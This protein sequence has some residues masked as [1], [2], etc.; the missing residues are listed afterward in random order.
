M[1]IQRIPRYLLLLKELIKHT[2]ESHPDFTNLNEAHDKIQKV[3]NALNEAER[4]AE[5]MHKIYLI[6]TSLEGDYD[7]R[8]TVFSLPLPSCLSLTN[9]SRGGLHWNRRT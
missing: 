2:P 9:T 8:F 5:S 1:P 6:Q 7:V 3:A 4:E